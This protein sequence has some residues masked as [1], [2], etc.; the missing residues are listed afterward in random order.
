MLDGTEGIGK[1][2]NETNGDCVGDGA[3]K[4]SAFVGSTTLT[5]KRKERNI[6]FLL[7]VFLNFIYSLLFLLQELL[8]GLL[9][10]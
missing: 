5:C 9:N 6:F 4:Q 7:C 2:Q 3:T 1:E 8:Q 10:T